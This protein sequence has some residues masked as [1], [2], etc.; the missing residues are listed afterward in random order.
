MKKFDNGDMVYAPDLPDT[1]FL[2]SANWLNSS[3]QD[4]YEIKSVV[5]GVRFVVN[6]RYLAIVPPKSYE[7]LY[8][9]QYSVVAGKWKV[10]RTDETLVIPQKEIASF[11]TEISAAEYADWKNR[12]GN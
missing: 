11:A 7:I 1:K 9:I 5:D 3:G 6:E 8:K 4:V 2:V 12:S 10:Y